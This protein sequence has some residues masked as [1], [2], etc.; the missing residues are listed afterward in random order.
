MN[1]RLLR[2]RPQAIRFS[3]VILA[4][5]A[6]PGRAQES[7]PSAVDGTNDVAPTGST[8]L[9]ETRDPHDGETATRDGDAGTDRIFGILPNYTTVERETAASRITTRQSFH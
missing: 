1:G 4:L 8:D 5:S 7:P 2:L 3:A 9:H 6:I